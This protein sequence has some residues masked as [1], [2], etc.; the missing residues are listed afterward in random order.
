MLLV[1]SFHWFGFQP[2]LATIKT[3]DLYLLSILLLDDLICDRL[4]A[5]QTLFGVTFKLF[6]EGSFPR[7]PDYSLA[8]LSIK[9]QVGKPCLDGRLLNWVGS[10][11]SVWVS[12]LRSSTICLDSTRTHSILGPISK[13]FVSCRTLPKLVA[14]RVRQTWSHIDSIYAWAE[15]L[16]W[17]D[18]DFENSCHEFHWGLEWVNAVIPSFLFPLNCAAVARAKI[19][20]PNRHAVCLRDSGSFWNLCSEVI[21][22]DFFADPTSRCWLRFGL[23]TVP[24]EH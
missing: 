10:S 11:S 4:I 19:T 14:I 9:V 17:S 6:L 1:S 20:G 12:A 23:C 3:A 24:E 15:I 7:P 16:S 22:R 5:I 21:Q 18:T 13:H 2:F 8:H